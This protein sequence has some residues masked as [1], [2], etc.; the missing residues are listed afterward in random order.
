MALAGRSQIPLLRRYITRRGLDIDNP[1]IAQITQAA[2]ATQNDNIRLSFLQG[3]LDALDGREDQPA[4]PSWP[5][6]Y[7][8]VKASDN[9]S[10]RSIGVRLATLFG[11]QQTIDHLRDTVHNQ[12]ADPNLRR[13][14]LQALLKLKDGVPTAV[15]HELVKAPILRR[16]AITALVTHSESST[17]DVLLA[18]Y[19]QLEPV[20]QQD[21]IGV[22]V[23]R[24]DFAESLLA[25]IGKGSINRRDIS[26]FALQQL[27]AFKDADIKKRVD[28]LWVDDTQQ[29][30]KADQIAHYNHKMTPE[31]LERGNLHTGRLFFE[32]TCAKCHTL[33]GE[34][35]TVGPD[36]TGSG[37]TNLDYLLSNLID[38]SAIIDPAYCLTQ[39]LTNDGK[40]LSGFLV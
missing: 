23:T 9:P 14:S 20:E 18:A 11:D 22:L 40:M 16:D 36:L 35:A 13:K 1:P 29:L 19:S 31:Y 15:L 2:A 7:T 17:A 27:R 4:P 28:A 38:P 6:V 34:G 26:A 10:L 24:R 12:A 3:M 5:T 30:T 39:I 32:R 37:R 25:A 33:F 21:A 8:Q